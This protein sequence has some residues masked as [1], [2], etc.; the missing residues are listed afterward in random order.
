M[1]KASDFQQS[2]AGLVPWIVEYSEAAVCGCSM[3][4]SS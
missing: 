2:T 4:G 1:E 3:I